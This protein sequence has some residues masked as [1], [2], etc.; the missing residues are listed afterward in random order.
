MLTL[1]RKLVLTGLQTIWFILRRFGV[2]IVAVLALWWRID[3]PAESYVL[4]LE[5]SNWITTSVLTDGFLKRMVN[6]ILVDQ[7]NGL[8]TGIIISSLF[9]FIWWL[10]SMPFRFVGS[11]LRS[12]LKRKNKAKKIS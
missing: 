10:L 8:M 5:A 4:L 1:L 12:L 11:K 9:S 2:I 6:L 7:F 3:Y